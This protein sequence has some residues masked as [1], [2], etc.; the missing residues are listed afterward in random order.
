MNRYFYLLIVFLALGVFTVSAQSSGRT[1][2]EVDTTETPK[3]SLN[4]ATIYASDANYYGQ[5]STERLPY[6][7][8]N[9]SLNF[10]SGFFLS[11]GAY[12][13]INFGSGVSG[14]DL[15]AGYDFKITKNLSSS[16]SFTRSFFPDSS[17]LLQATNLNMASGSLSYD[18]QWLTT[19][20]YADYAIGDESALFM[21]FNAS[22]LIDLGSLFSPKDYISFEPSFQL[23]GGT[24]RI[25]TTEEIPKKGNGNGVIPPFIR[26][27][28]NGS[29]D[30]KYRQIES[31]SFDL[32]SYNFK[33]P[34]A[35]NRANYAVEATYQA[36]ILSN[37][38]EGAAQKPR[39]FLYLGFYYIF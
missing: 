14:I 5:A 32:L 13:L 29:Q 4:L 26:L 11:A 22:K 31:T 33:L 36:S 12:K 39:S 18:W 30:P 35:Y 15:S 2:T 38:V 21:T 37:K 20:V 10:T 23:V 7:L 27:R 8:A 16:L 9:A 17:L 19:G 25:T 28:G 6:V 34:L 24:Q 3:T 1:D